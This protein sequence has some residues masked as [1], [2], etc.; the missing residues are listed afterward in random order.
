M[1]I[2]RIL[3]IFLIRVFSS[4]ED[5]CSNVKSRGRSLQVSL[6]LGLEIRFFFF[7]FCPQ[8]EIHR[9]VPEDT[10][11]C[12]TGLFALAVSQPWQKWVVAELELQ[13]VQGTNCSLQRGRRGKKKKLNYGCN[14][15]E[16]C[17]TLLSKAVS[18]SHKTWILIISVSQ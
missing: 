18:T 15:K 9:V 16:T 11:N 1:W 4:T 17:F 8:L 10:G 6:K 5:A 3:K 13:Q 2:G 7:S 14:R 12:R